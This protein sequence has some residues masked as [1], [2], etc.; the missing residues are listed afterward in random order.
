MEV[1]R[2]E[3]LQLDDI[4]ELELLV[5]EQYKKLERLSKGQQCTAVLNILLIDNKDPLIIEQPEDNL[6][7]AFIADSLIAT[8]REN[9][10]K[11]AIHFCYA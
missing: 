10:I 2:L 9:K 1:Y 8:I 4:Y 3:E 6:D 11:K 5:N 7:N